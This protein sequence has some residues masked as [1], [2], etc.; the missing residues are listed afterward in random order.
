MSFMD[1]SGQHALAIRNLQYLAAL[2]RE[3]HFARA[4]AS[5]NVTQPTLSK[6]IKQLEESLDVMIVERGQ[7]FVRLTPAGERVLTWA[8]RIL[9]DY[10]SLKQE[11]TQARSELTGE[12][13]LGAIPVALPLIA[14]LTAD[15]AEQNPG[16]TIK[17][18]SHSFAE[19]QRGL[20]DF[21]LSA[22]LTY[23]DDEPLSGVRS[24]PLYDEHYVL[25][26][27][28][29]GPLG[30][31]DTVSWR[32]VAAIPLCLLTPDMQNRRILDRHFAAA[33]VAVRARIETNS[34][35]TLWSH[36]RFSGWSSILPHTFLPLLDNVE[37]LRGIPLVEPSAAHSIGLV[38][39]S[40][41]PLP[42]VTQAF[43]A[44]ARRFDLAKALAGHPAPHD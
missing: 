15:F 23:L 37:G 33:G 36:L 4:A 3:Q 17:V 16:V 44:H 43:I 32:E 39:T 40:H 11:L 28:A 8:H 29:D 26:T 18:S 5:C 38:L 19:I 21:S 20:Y 31:R 22:G 25:L 1:P 6:G 12:L 24:L 34:M 30:E 41:D 42:P 9:S 7:R 27:R 35:I 14:L 13:K 10:T 2:A